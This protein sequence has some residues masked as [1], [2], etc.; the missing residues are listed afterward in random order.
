MFMLKRR[1]AE[2]GTCSPALPYRTA[3][4]VL[5]RCKE[6]VQNELCARF[7]VQNTGLPHGLDG[8]R[9]VARAVAQFS[10]FQIGARRSAIGALQCDHGLIVL[11]GSGTV[12]RGRGPRSRALQSRGN[13]PGV[14]P[15]VLG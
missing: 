15:E 9:D 13:E 1:E 5:A 6:A 12:F 2:R 3:P 11:D 7:G 14:A 4:A 10:Q 8:S